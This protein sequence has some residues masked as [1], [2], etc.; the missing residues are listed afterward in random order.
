[1]KFQEFLEQD[2]LQGQLLLVLSYSIQ[3]LNCVLAPALFCIATDNR[4]GCVCFSVEF[5]TYLRYTRQLDFF[6][7]PD[8]DY[9]R[10][11]FT[12]LIATNG[13]Q[14]DWDFDWSARHTVCGCHSCLIRLLAGGLVYW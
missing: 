8:Y 13:W 10:G 5:S 6:E 12:G 9:V 7:T 2:F 4:N 14:C 11:L 3:Y 1:M